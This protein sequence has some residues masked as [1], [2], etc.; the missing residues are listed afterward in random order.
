MLSE[1]ARRE[2]IPT[3]SMMATI[4]EYVPKAKQL[5]DKVLEARNV[6]KEWWDIWK[7][8]IRIRPLA[9]EVR[10][11]YYRFEFLFSYGFFTL[12]D[13][14][15]ISEELMKYGYTTEELDLMK[16]TAEM[17]RLQRVWLHLIPSPTAL[18]GYYRYS[19][20]AKTLLDL[21]LGKILDIEV[22]KQFMP[23]RQARELINTIKTFY[24][25][26]LVARTV[27][28]DVRGYIYDLIRAYEYGVINDAELNAELNYL[29]QFG[30]KDIN[31]ELIKRRAKLRRRIRERFRH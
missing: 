16:K 12:P 11:M 31:I 4:V 15:R 17:Y 1:V 22:L 5:I 27:Y 2:Y 23:E 7:E 13:F 3:P 20:V 26:M 28:P 8:Y 6:P 14:K 19:D 25:Q 24:E 10:R 30:L 18:T 21:K 29:K 9:S